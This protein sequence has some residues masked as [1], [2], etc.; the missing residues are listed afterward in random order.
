MATR[1][2]QPPAGDAPAPRAHEDTWGANPEAKEK[3]A[4]ANPPKSETPEEKK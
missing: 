3:Y 1:N 2:Q 4:A